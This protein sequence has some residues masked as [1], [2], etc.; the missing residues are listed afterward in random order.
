MRKYLAVALAFICSVALAQNVTR[1]YPREKLEADAAR[2]GEQIKAEYQ[3][4]ILPQL[5]ENERSALSA[6]KIEFPTSGPNGD[7][8]E[9][10]TDGNTIY[11]P[12]LSLRFY[13]DLCV[14]NAWLNAHEF[15]GTTVRDY[16]GLLFREAAAS[17]RAPLP[18]VFRTLGVPD[19]ARD[20]PAVKNRADRNFANTIVFLLTH[21]L[22]HVLKKHRPDVRDPNQRR[23]QEIAAD[24][25]AI[26]VMR[27][28]GQLPLGLEFWFDVER[29]RHVA[30][31]KF[32]T[33]SDWQNYLASLKHPVSKERLEAL[34][35]AIE[36]AP[37]SFARIQTDQ[38]LWAARSKM[39]AQM[40]RL[41][42][43][44]AANSIARVAEYSRVRELR[45]ADL[46]PR[47]AA[48]SVPGITAST[49]QDFNGLFRVRRTAPAGT[50]VIDLLLLRDGD[51]VRGAY[52]KQNLSGSLEGKVSGSVLHFT[53]SEGSAHGGGKAETQADAFHGTWGVGEA[54]QGGGEFVAERQKKESAQQ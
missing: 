30:P 48:F 29:I 11:L 20:E 50:D 37:E 1:L 51:D 9:F 25:F 15:D 3:E 19:T 5:N 28:M 54:E 16:V 31:L 43:P 6:V 22:G 13:A 23:A 44:F 18:P 4:T 47:K 35:A 34:A 53:W 10:Y 49:A 24:A 33:D 32:P 14:A 45:L 26:E 52:M 42:A 21:E 40:F 46:K 27:R 41:A 12:A 38:A 36:A 7:P 8:F 17:P 39:F 2:S